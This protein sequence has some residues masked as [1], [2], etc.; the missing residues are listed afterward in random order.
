MIPYSNQNSLIST[1]YSRLNCLKTLPFTVAHTYIAYSG[2]P[3]A[4]G[5]HAEPHTYRAYAFIFIWSSSLAV[6]GLRAHTYDDD[7][8]AQ[9]G[10]NTG[11]LMHCIHLCN[12]IM[13]VH[14]MVN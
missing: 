7:D 2:A 4:K 14:F 12:L 9:H 5:R 6:N 10:A 13:E 8:V 3:A 1:P 11:Q